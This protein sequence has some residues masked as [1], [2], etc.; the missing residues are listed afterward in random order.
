MWL[1][2]TLPQKQPPYTFYP[3]ASTGLGRL[4][5]QSEIGAERGADSFSTVAACDR[6]PTTFPIGKS[7]PVPHRL[8]QPLADYS[9][10]S[11]GSAAGLGCV[12]LKRPNISLSVD[13]TKFVSDLSAALYILSRCKN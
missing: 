4:P 11:A 6:W 10:V 8:N 5:R 1:K 9:A 2:L 7:F 3:R 12:D 13:K